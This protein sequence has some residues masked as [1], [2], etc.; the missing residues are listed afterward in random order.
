MVIL[1]YVNFPR[2]YAIE[3]AVADGF[4]HQASTL[5][6]IAAC[7]AFGVKREMVLIIIAIDLSGVSSCWNYYTVT[8]E[9]VASA[10]SRR[11]GAHSQADI[12]TA[13]FE[14]QLLVFDLLLVEDLVG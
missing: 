8:Q 9:A 11:V 7:T 1:Y 2:I 12:A 6:S 5:T 13:A 10:T 14:Q 4:D 3:A